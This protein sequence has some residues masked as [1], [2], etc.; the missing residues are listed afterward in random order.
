MT[1]LPHRDCIGL[2]WHV[3]SV[4]KWFGG[5]GKAH[6]TWGVGLKM[7]CRGSLGRIDWLGGP[8]RDRA[9]RAGES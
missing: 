2:A 7:A 4:Q 1:G 5:A 6:S 9:V 3:V 8:S